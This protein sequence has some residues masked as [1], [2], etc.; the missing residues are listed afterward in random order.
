MR[1]TVKEKV[2]AF[3]DDFAIKNEYND[4]QYYVSSKFLSF[5]NDLTLLDFEK[6]PIYRIKQKVLSFVPTYFIS[7]TEGDVVATIK[8]KFTIFN[9]RFIIDSIFGDFNVE[10]NFLGREFSVYL[11]G[12]LQAEVSKKFFS[13][14]D[15]YSINIKNEKRA[16]L[17]LALVI[18]IDQA[19]YDRKSNSNNH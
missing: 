19:L 8:K 2:F 16:E 4:V 5:G 7:D 9:N 12:E 18:T 15:T 3:K 10:G 1:L 13:F 11:D 6:K 17:F 14:A